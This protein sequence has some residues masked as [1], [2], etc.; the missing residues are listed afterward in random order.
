MTVVPGLVQRV[1]LTAPVADWVKAIRSAADD[2]GTGQKTNALAA[3]RG[4]KLDVTT[5]AHELQK[6]YAALAAGTI[7][8][9]VM[10]VS[11]TKDPAATVAKRWWAIVTVAMLLPPVRLSFTGTMSGVSPALPLV[12]A[13]LVWWMMRLAFR[14]VKAPPGARISLLLSAYVFVHGTFVTW[15][16]GAPLVFL[17]Q[18][19]W[20][21]YLAAFALCAA[22][23]TASEHSRGVA[24][25]MVLVAAL[26]EACLGFYTSAFGPLVDSGTWYGSRFGLSFYR[27][28][29]TFVSAN[30]LAGF[31]AVVPLLS[32][33]RRSTTCRLGAVTW[34]GGSLLVC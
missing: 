23:V 31:L 13:Y 14:P 15:D 32:A 29:G 10:L 19:Q 24:I 20:A 4:S 17:M 34:P 9:T 16:A 33:S 21:V 25:R 2:Q 8:R 11:T 22:A 26:V 28:T 1:S 18:A 12:M 27:A 3:L 5:S 6:H 7:R 30:G